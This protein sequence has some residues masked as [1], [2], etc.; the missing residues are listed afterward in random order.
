[1][2]DEDFDAEEVAVAAGAGL[3]AA[4][5]SGPGE[6]LLVVHGQLRWGNQSHFNPFNSS[7]GE[8]V[9]EHSEHISKWD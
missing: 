2:A 1:M 6:E 5:D 8:N 7:L 9:T 3:V 4:V